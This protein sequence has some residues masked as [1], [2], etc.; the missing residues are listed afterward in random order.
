MTQVLEL[1]QL[2]NKDGMTQVQ[3]GCR[4]IETGLDA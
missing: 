4:R 1:A 3:V 2:V